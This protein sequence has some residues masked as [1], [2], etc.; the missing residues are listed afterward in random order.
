MEKDEEENDRGRDRLRA[1][2]P[3]SISKVFGLEQGGT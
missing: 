1:T 3:K 2:I